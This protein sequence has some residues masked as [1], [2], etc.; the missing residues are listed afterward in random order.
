MIEA[1]RRALDAWRGRGAHAVTVP[2]MDGA[3]QPNQAIEDAPVLLDIAAPDNLV[4]AGARL[5]FSSGGTVRA[6]QTDG[7]SAAAESFASFE[8]PVAALAAHRGGGVAIGLDAG[9]VE[10]RGGPHDGKV[11]ADLNGRALVCPTALM[12][13][14]E[15]TLLVALGSQQN[16]PEKW[17]HDLMQRNASGSVWRVDLRSGAATCL[18]DRLAWPC[19]LLPAGDGAV[20]VAESWRNRLIRARA[21][22]RPAPVL[23]DIAGYP[24]RLAPAADGR[25][26]WL[27]V[28]APRSQLVEFV[29]RERDYRE[30][31]MQEVDPELWIAPSLSS[32]RSFLEPM[33]VG[34]LMQLGILK[35]WAPTRSYGLI[36]RLDGEGEPQQSFHS[37]ADGRRH[38]VTSCVELDGR[39]L[40][41]AKGGDAILSIPVTDV[42]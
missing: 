4:Q 14:D 35:P 1:W 40:A 36:V 8:S 22:G 42:R 16:P 2:P 20:I 29:L 31:M 39:L 23:T 10:L 28:F 6:L 32:G 19:G 24:S 7:I 11:L 15:S 5:L 26:A 27:A 25:G 30:A 3:L 37:R 17:K 34:G 13:A 12:F 33:Q 41:T 38:G 18:A 21:A 9:R